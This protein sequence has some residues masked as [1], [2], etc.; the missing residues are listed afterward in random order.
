MFAIPGEPFVEIGLKLKKHASP[1]KS[2]VIGLANG[3][4][5]YIPTQRAYG[6]VGYETRLGRWSYLEKD[7]GENIIGSF[8]NMLKQISM[9]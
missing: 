8:L 7:A 1:L 6:E 5:G 9:P 4:V 3:W 2:M